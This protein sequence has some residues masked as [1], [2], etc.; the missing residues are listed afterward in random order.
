MS[1]IVA[2]GA[3]SRNLLN[4]RTV[5]Y[6]HR[7]VEHRR[8]HKVITLHEVVERNAIRVVVMTVVRLLE[9]RMFATLMVALAVHRTAVCASG[10]PILGHARKRN[11][12][13]AEYP[14]EIYGQ[15]GC[16]F[17][18]SVHSVQKKSKKTGSRLAIG[19]L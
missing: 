11:D 6:L 3:D 10:S 4:T 13:T 7:G 16:Y 15:Q 18:Q 12:A 8:L 17:C 14:H 5:V 19:G 9:V 1:L 2:R